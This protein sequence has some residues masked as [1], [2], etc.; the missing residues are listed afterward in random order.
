MELYG[1]VRRACMVEG[2][3]TREAARVYGLHRDTVRN[4]LKHS[5]PPGYRR[6][7]LPRRSKLDLYRGVIDRI[8]DEEVVFPR[9]RGTQPSAS[10][11][12]CGRS[13]G[14]AASTR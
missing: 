14:S 2:M 8:L 11:S 3:S 7:R 9:S 12:V 1:R 4:M 10:T 6:K 13:T 5:V